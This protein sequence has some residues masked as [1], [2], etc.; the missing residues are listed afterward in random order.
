MTENSA[1][2]TNPSAAKIDLQGL[3][4]AEYHFGPLLHLTRATQNAWTNYSINRLQTNQKYC[5]LVSDPGKG[6]GDGPKADEYD[7]CSW[8][9]DNA[10]AS[11]SQIEKEMDLEHGTLQKCI[12]IAGNEMLLDA[13]KGTKPRS[14]D[15]TVRIYSPS[16]PMHI[17]VH[18]QYY[19]RSRLSS[20]QWFYSL[21]FKIYRRP[22]ATAG[23]VSVIKKDLKKVRP[24]YV[25]T[26]NGWQNLC[27]GFYDHYDDCYGQ[28]EWRP[29][30]RGKVD[31]HE[32]NVQDV[33]E[34]LFGEL[35]KPADNDPE[36]MLAYRRSLVRGIRL[37]LAAVG[38]SY[39][40][41][42]TDDEKD[43][44]PRDLTLGGLCETWVGRRIRNVCGIR[45]VRDAQEEQLGVSLRRYEARGD[46]DDFD[47]EDDEDDDNSDFGF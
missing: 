28:K 18:F 38:I 34:V 1:D 4:L 29:V 26:R 22:S 40:V 5:T 16:A 2:S 27:W 30:E 8:L 41:A 10:K 45:L 35:E 13:G 36:A 20:A 17:D 42:C 39:D 19:L 9:F 46:D 44:P 6:S 23:D 32:E 43:E 47:S 33:H 7:E 14:V 21:G 11:V 31:L 3:E 25:H 24:P 37:L 12:T 15:M